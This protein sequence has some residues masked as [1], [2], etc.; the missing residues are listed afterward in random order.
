MSVY[1]FVSLFVCLS[2]IPSRC[3]C[4]QG[5]SSALR[6]HDNFLLVL[7]AQKKYIYIYISVLLSASVERVGV[8]RMRDFYTVILVQRFT[9]LILNIVAL[10]QC[11][12]ELIKPFGYICIIY[13]RVLTD[14][15]DPS[16]SNAP[17][18]GPI[19]R[20]PSREEIRFLLDIV[21]KS[22]KS[23]GGKLAV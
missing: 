22:H 5:L 13:F 20:R 16:V 4:F 11:F 14:Q 21:L 23:Q 17:G 18:R 1:L 15:M 3:I 19:V 8:S 12:T 7:V 9:E 10:V 2:D 6:S